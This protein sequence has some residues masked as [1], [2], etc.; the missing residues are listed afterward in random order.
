MIICML[1]CFSNM[2]WQSKSCFVFLISEQDR[3]YVRKWSSTYL[4]KS[5]TNHWNSVADIGYRKVCFWYLK[6]LIGSELKLW[7]HDGQNF[8]N[9]SY[10]KNG[11]FQNHFIKKRSRKCGFH[12]SDHT[13]RDRTKTF[14][15]LCSD[16]HFY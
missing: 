10:Q 11:Q 9:V 7:L 1:Y 13:I 12:P 6:T 5:I 2:N 3:I 16:W 8:L 14:T 15:F 4:Y